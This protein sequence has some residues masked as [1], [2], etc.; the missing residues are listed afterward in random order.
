MGQLCSY[1]VDCA[2]RIVSANDEFCRA[3]RVPS[4]S[5]V[6]RDVR[7]LV[8]H[9]WRSD[10]SSYV[11]KALVRAGDDT[12]T[13]PIVTPRAGE[14]WFMHTLEAILDAGTVSGYRAW[15]VPHE[16]TRPRPWYRWR[17]THAHHVWNF[18]PS[19]RDS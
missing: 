1:H 7:D 13:V 18:E 10:F 2:W 19:A 17:R 3:V 15:L 5:L 16:P 6:G 12:V 11:A 4:A 14:T 8:R 9:D